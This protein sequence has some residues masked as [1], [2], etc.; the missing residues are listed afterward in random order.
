MA[1][2]GY[3]PERVVRKP[4]VKNDG[5][6][7]VRRRHSTRKSSSGG[8]PG[9]DDVRPTEKVVGQPKVG[10]RFTEFLETIKRVEKL[11]CGLDV[12][13]QS[14]ERQLGQ[15]LDGDCDG[16]KAQE[17]AVERWKREAEMVVNTMKQVLGKSRL[18][19]SGVSA[20]VGAVEQDTGSWANVLAANEVRTAKVATKKE[21]APV[22][23]PV[24]EA[25]TKEGAK[26]VATKKEEAPVEDETLS[27]LNV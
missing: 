8:R 7:P 23:K 12:R 1:L 19:T 21:E 26:E 27:F 13:I 10:E 14:V 17:E 20:T 24:K 25:T 15:I 9:G 6:A 22:K 5:E 11:V 18:S 3:T 2:F 16:M 4:T